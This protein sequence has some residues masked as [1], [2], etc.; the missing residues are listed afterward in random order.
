MWSGAPYPASTAGRHAHG[1]PTM[2]R[3]A[4]PAI[5]T[6]TRNSRSRTSRYPQTA[7][8]CSSHTG[9][10]STKNLIDAGRYLQPDRMPLRIDPNRRLAYHAL[11]RQQDS[12]APPARVESATQSHR[13]PICRQRLHTRQQPQRTAKTLRHHHSY[14]GLNRKRIDHRHIRRQNRNKRFGPVANQRIV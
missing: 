2:S 9:A 7:P 13:P 14:F 12:L 11:I 1:S 3:P 6:P 8:P 4:M 5:A 10:P